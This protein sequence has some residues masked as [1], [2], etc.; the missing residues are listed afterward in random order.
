MKKLLLSLLL[1]PCL[2]FA[3]NWNGVEGVTSFNGVENA[4]QWN[5][6]GLSFQAEDAL[7]VL[8]S[9]TVNSS[10]DQIDL[11]WNESVTCNA[12]T[13]NRNITLFGV[14]ASVDTPATGCAG[15]SSIVYPL[16]GIVQAT[17]TV[18]ANLGPAWTGTGGANADI[19][20]FAVTNNSTQD[21]VAPTLVSAVITNGPDAF[22]LTFSENV[23]GCSGGDP[24]GLFVDDG[25]G[26]NVLGSCQGAPNN[27]PVIECL[28]SLT[29]GETLD[30]SS[31]Q[32]TGSF[33]I[34]IATNP[35]A[36]FTGFATTGP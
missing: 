16:A 29:G 6:T 7:P 2:L 32:D 19:S 25:H 21:T 9:A 27:S 20:D 28:A 35:L 8:L 12:S 23:T 34:D 15:S 26:G 36:D 1:F 14:S 4:Q 22:T 11:H 24:C 5:G 10:G 18:T 3:G 30:Y 33:V 31:T 17:D 13:S